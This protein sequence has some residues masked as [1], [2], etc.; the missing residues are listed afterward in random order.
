MEHIPVLLKETIELLDPKPGENFVDCTFGRGGHS[1]AILDKNFPGGR[2]LAKEL[3]PKNL[4][5]FYKEGGAGGDQRIKIVEGNFADLEKILEEN[6]F[7]PVNGILFDLGMSSW[8][9]DSSGKGFSFSKDEPLDMRYSRKSAISA[10][11]IVNSYSRQGLEKI[12]SEYGEE[13]YADQIAEK[14]TAA[15]EMSPIKT[16]AH[17]AAVVRKALPARY[18]SRGNHW[19][20]K[21]FQAIRIEANRELENIKSALPQALAALEPQG[22]LAVISFHSLEDSI[23]KSFF[24]A[25][26]GGGAARILTEKPITPSKEE[27]EKNPRSRSAKLRV[28]KKI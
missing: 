21:T 19:A 7:F 15:R 11:D 28:L 1:R 17:L 5:D 14:I 25:C 9:V 8:H 27:V 13:K 23:V 2:V 26:S 4:E 16:T 20:A 24:R 10:C 6:K 22:R 3:D 12:I 18:P